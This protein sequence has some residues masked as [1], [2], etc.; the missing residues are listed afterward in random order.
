MNRIIEF[1]VRL[2]HLKNEKRKIATFPN[3]K[4]SE[5][6]YESWLGV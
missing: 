4:N 1:F 5:E 3:Y 6:E 2:F